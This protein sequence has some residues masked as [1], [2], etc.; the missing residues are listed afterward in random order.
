MDDFSITDERLEGALRDLRWTNRLLGGYAATR[1]TLRPL[2]QN[3]SRLRV[4]D[5]GT[6]GGDSLVD[7]IRFGHSQACRLEVVG[8]DLN[9]GAV[10]Y[11]RGHLDRTLSPR[12]R[13]RVDVRVGDALNLDMPDDHF[14]VA[15]ASLFLHHFEADDAATLLR[16]MDRVARHGIIINDL[17][18]HMLAYLGVLTLSRLLPASSMYRHDAPLSVRRGFRADEL[19]SIALAAGLSSP[20]IR[21]HWAFRWTLSTLTR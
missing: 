13:T 7:L 9:A 6:G 2:L 18:R 14:D 4:L 12:M 3:H 10:E 17:H 15:I 11:A 1:R 21:W 5:I 16:E 19:R 8:I 20:D